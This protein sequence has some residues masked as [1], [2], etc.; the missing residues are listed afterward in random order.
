MKKLC[1]TS[2]V[3]LILGWSTGLPAQTAEGLARPPPIPEESE[4]Y[5]PLM[6]DESGDVPIPPKIQ[7]EQVEPTV[8]IIEEEDRRIE[9]YRVNGKIYMVKV[10]PNNGPPYYYIDHDGDGRLELDSKEQAMNPVAPVTK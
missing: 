8:R 3:L 9:E 1:W 2:A 6:P 5:Q 10:T 4:D 7:E